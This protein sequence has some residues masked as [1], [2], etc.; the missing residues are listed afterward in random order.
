MKL[1]KFVSLF[2]SLALVLSLV[3]PVQAQGATEITCK[4]QT[5]LVNA[6]A[7]A[8]T[9]PDA[10]TIINIG[11]N[12]SIDGQVEVAAGTY[13]TL[14]S[15]ASSI[16]SLKA[17]TDY[18]DQDASGMVMV[19][20]TLTLQNVTLD[21]D[22]KGRVVVM[23]PGSSMTLESGA[24]IC[25]GQDRGT[26]SEVGFGIYVQNGSSSQTT[27]LVM[28]EGS[29]I[30]ECRYTGKGYRWE[31]GGIGIYLGN[32][33]EFTMTGGEISDNKDAGTGLKNSPSA[34]GGGV[35]L[36]N[37]TKMVMTG[38]QIVGNFA[39]YGGGG[40]YISGVNQ[41]SEV[42]LKGDA[43]IADNNLSYDD[44]VTEFAYLNGAGVYN[45]GGI[46]RISEN[47]SIR[48]NSILTRDLEN[49]SGCG[50]GVFQE[51]GVMYMDGGS[52]TGNVARMEYKERDPAIDPLFIEGC[53]GGIFLRSGECYISGGSIT[54][55]Q[56][57][58]DFIDDAR[59][60][61]G[62]GICVAYDHDPNNSYISKLLLSGGQISDNSADKAGQDIYLVNDMSLISR[63]TKL[64]MVQS[65][66]DC[67]KH[68]V[69][70]VSG[71]PV[72]GEIY[73]PASPAAAP[74]MEPGRLTIDGKLKD[75]ASLGLM[76]QKAETGYIVAEAGEDYLLRNSDARPLKLLGTTSSGM[77]IVMN[78][79]AQFEL[80]E[81]AVSQ[82]TS[83][84]AASITIADVTYNGEKQ[85]PEPVVTLNGTTLL[86][87]RDYSVS[88]EKNLKAG[89][90][91]VVI[92][93]IGNYN[94]TAEMNFQIKALSLSDASIQASSIADKYATGEALKP[95]PELT[96]AGA[97]LAGSEDTSDTSAD[98]TYSY[99]ANTQAGTG[100]ITLK[101][102]GNFTGTRTIS[103]KILSSGSDVQL[104]KNEGELKNALT[105]AAGSKASPVRIVL[106][107][108]IEV[109][110]P[111]EVA[112]GFYGI[113]SGNGFSISLTAKNQATST[114]P[115][116][117][118]VM[119]KGTSDLQADDITIKG[120]GNARLF[121]VGSLAKLTLGS[122]AA[123]RGGKAATTN[124]EALGGQTIYNEG[125]VT[126]A[127]SIKESLSGYYGTIYNAGSF[128]LEEGSWLEYLKS[129]NG[130]VIYNK[131]SFVM[132]GGTIKRAI[133]AST[134][135]A[136]ISNLG[137]F[138][139]KG[140]T[141]TGSSCSVPAVYN[142][143]S[144]I[145]NDGSIENNNNSQTTNLGAS[146]GTVYM[147]SGSFTMKGGSIRNN[148]ASEGGGVLM[149]G[150]T[151]TMCGSSAK[152][153]GNKALYQVI[154]T[155]WN[156]VDYGCG[157][158]VFMNAGH[159]LLEAGSITGNSADY[160]MAQG[161]DPANNGY[162]GGIFLNGGTLEIKG[163]TIADNTAHEA[164]TEGIYFGSQTVGA[165]A[166]ETP[167]L[168]LSG[169]PA[170]TDT[171]YLVKGKT[172][173]ITGPLN[174]NPVKVLQEN[175]QYNTVLAVYDQETDAR[176]TDGSMFVPCDGTKSYEYNGKGKITIS[177]LNLNTCQVSLAK[178]TYTYTG[179]SIVPDVTVVDSEG[180][181]IS[182]YVV[183][184]SN[185]VNCGSAVA[186]ICGDG[187]TTTGEV[188]V[189][190]TIIPRNLADNF[191]SFTEPNQIYTGSPLTPEVVVK[192][193]SR[194][195]VQDVDYT[196][197]Y[198]DNIDGEDG[199]HVGVVLVTGMGNFTGQAYGYFNIKEEAEISIS[200]TAS[201][202]C[203][204][205]LTL[206][207]TIV[208]GE[209]EGAA[210]CYKS[211]NTGIAKVNSKGLV[212]A[213]AAGTATITVT[214]KE[215]DD[216]HAAEAA[217]KVTV[218]KGTQTITGVN[219][220]IN[221]NYSTT[222]FTLAAKTSG[223]GSLKFKSS[224]TAVA[225]IGSTS[226]TVT[227]KGY[228]KS[229]ITITAAESK[230]YKEATRKVT[231]Y[232]KPKTLSIS[233]VTAP[234][235]GKVKVT[236]SKDAKVSGYQIQY[237]YSSSMSKAKTKTVSGSGSLSATL[238]G[239]TKG[240]TCYVQIRGYKMV[241]TK[242][243]VGAWS[244]TMS[245]KVK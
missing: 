173:S 222:K 200:K 53:G 218:T 151:F 97:V 7:S 72:V 223:D 41:S 144:F 239:L 208:K 39:R 46:L 118:L 148:T 32:Y 92:N 74:D 167:V 196:L 67:N 123:L 64:S 130:G 140:G 51:S 205:T 117:A 179:R 189:T 124:N 122:R 13:V 100:T 78:D 164:N 108:D 165:N 169:S 90:A 107:K 12:L 206:K 224:S 16:K 50:A 77:N 87:G 69:I 204:K 114:A 54:G 76:L 47:A 145:M 48:N 237:S 177:K 160:T 129:T 96:F 101:G 45:C 104:V 28:K 153:E 82:K 73:L 19:K 24:T 6:L 38:G 4:S 131:G 152:I 242:A 91:V 44:V 209:T 243:L 194:T 115:E 197:E 185:N 158:G 181:E 15:S 35:Q 171:L 233:K 98:Y 27:S 183:N 62:G 70:A 137:S 1:K 166:T 240:K 133:G 119:M 2:L 56:A 60:G 170:I 207:P 216:Y 86:K 42:V 195:L 75:G 26:H 215:S 217:V 84:A 175:L 103:F 99:G 18:P 190:Y 23:A 80:T 65:V 241:G 162:G 155:N 113:L 66:Y 34:A 227:M 11:S 83:L 63:T 188:E 116:T 120:N 220:T 168:K 214:L 234:S 126:L 184:A 43:V 178:S 199:D 138:T 232:V 55:N 5:E 109:G 231:L 235:T 176:A 161:K 79:A 127:G 105:K 125:T 9:D 201:V 213:V 159:F 192:Y 8:S 150:G 14:K 186:K 149:L 71:D 61:N 121:Y 135:G 85:R 238:T 49:Y 244:K 230:N 147:K 225:T 31:A 30:T 172:L 146:G 139:M 112:S 203:G 221:K 111:I 68:A 93:G 58:S 229:T 132:N 22:Y 36:A 212:T 25:H 37:H 211:S 52:I 191:V 57:V 202:S 182:G 198:Q 193:N 106:A 154:A 10:P 21:A 102:Q 245:V 228:G 156:V 180:N 110:G 187:Y 20:G 226:G 29:K 136:A 89:Q 134:L 157:G 174:M 142:E 143:G 59:T 33:S 94:D 3:P 141:I 88:Y 95:L 40:I 163:G 128:T 210:Y 236:W 17:V 219:T 81:S